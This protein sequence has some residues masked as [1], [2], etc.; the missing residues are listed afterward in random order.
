MSQEISTSFLQAVAGDI[1]KML[2][3][4]QESIAFAFK[5]IPDGIKLNLG[6]NLDWSKDGI[7]V[8]YALA[9]DLE[10]KPE[11]IEKHKVT[12]KRII[13]EDQS[14]L[15][16]IGSKIEKG[17]MSIEFPDGTKIGKVKG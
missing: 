15:E 14:S 16:F 7:V 4:D 11:P 1:E 13:N 2:L 3:E 5:K 8:N 12:L 6:I 9:F 10:P 17:E